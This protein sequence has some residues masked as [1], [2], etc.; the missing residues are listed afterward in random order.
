MTYDIIIFCEVVGG[1]EKSLLC[2][3]GVSDVHLGT[4]AT[5]TT[6]ELDVFGHDGDALGVDRAQVRVLEQT[7]E[8]SLAG[9]LEGHDGGRLEA[10]VS[11]EVLSDLADEALEGQLAD[12]QLRGLLVT[13]DF[14]EGD[15]A[16]PVPMWLLHSAGGR[17]ALASGLGGQLLTR[18]L[19]TGRFTCCLLGTS[20]YFLFYSNEE[21]TPKR[22]VTPYIMPCACHSLD[23]VYAN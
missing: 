14:T 2:V 7:D 4:F 21:Y 11:L 8:V 12:Q 18:G 17:G 19:A 10:E 3:R 23:V 15:C 13:T 16:G 20:H 22:A 5:D 6:G 1:P 9:L